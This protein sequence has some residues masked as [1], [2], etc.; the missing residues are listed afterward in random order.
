MHCACLATMAV[1]KSSI[2]SAENI[3]YDCNNTIIVPSFTQ[4]TTYTHA[5]KCECATKKLHTDEYPGPY[6]MSEPEVKVVMEYIRCITPVYGAIDLHSHGQ[7]VLYPYR[8]PVMHTLLECC[9][10]FPPIG[11]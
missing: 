9:F 7:L 6:Q 5:T 3:L 2:Q 11:Y 8:K 1:L 4:P 10:I